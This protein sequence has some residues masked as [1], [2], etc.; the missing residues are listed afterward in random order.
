[1][2]CTL[3][4]TRVIDQTKSI[5]SHDGLAA[6]EP[7]PPQGI[8]PRCAVERIRSKDAVS[9]SDVKQKQRRRGRGEGPTRD[10]G[11]GP[12]E[13]EPRRGPRRGGEEETETRD[14]GWKMLRRPSNSDGG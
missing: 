8:C 13:G 11:P 2:W 4:A 12:A 1:M 9:H 14:D 6:I 7:R 5:G 3:K 10:Q